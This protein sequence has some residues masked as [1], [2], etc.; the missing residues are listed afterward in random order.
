M[1]S[2][3][4]TP[5]YDKQFGKLDKRQQQI[6]L[7]KMHKIVNQPELGKPLHAPFQNRRSE[8]VENLRII[9]KHEQS[10]VTFLYFDDRGHVYG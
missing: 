9:Y 2:F 3:S 5:T 4:T 8:R 1:T 6:V 10:H 7:K